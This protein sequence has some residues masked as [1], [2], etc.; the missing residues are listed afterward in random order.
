[1][2]R[3]EIENKKERLEKNEKGETKG[4]NRPREKTRDK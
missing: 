2:K 4:D 1:M 3:N